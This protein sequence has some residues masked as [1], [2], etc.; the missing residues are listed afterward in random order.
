MA[1]KL[2]ALLL[3]ICGL[4]AA[5]CWPKKTATP[6][7]QPAGSKFGT[8]A[9]DATPKETEPNTP[10]EPAEVDPLKRLELEL[11]K[12]KKDNRRLRRRLE[13]QEAARASLEERYAGLEIELASSVEEVLRSKASLR[14]VHNRALAISR[15][16][17]VR[18]QLQSVPQAKDPEVA[19]R[20]ERANDFLNRADK[21]LAEGNFGG[22]S[23][24]SERAGEL[25]RQ[26]RMVAEVRTSF[27]GG[28]DRIIPIVPARNLETVVKA[29][30]RQAPGK[31]KSIVGQVDKGKQILAIARWGDWFQVEAGD[32]LRSWIHT[33]VVR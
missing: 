7:T 15:I 23:Y 4:L 13:D 16:A 27:L 8:D 31:D 22:S 24:L 14:N 12:A 20:L 3:A 6:S 29:N 2:T 10:E 30:L 21:A 9:A 33:S 11:A 5:G 28:S 19:V 18:V 17:E 32:G 25:V 1:T 26:A